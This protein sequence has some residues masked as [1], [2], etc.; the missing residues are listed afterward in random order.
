MSSPM[1]LLKPVRLTR[2]DLKL[3][4]WSAYELTSECV[5][6][7]DIREEQFE[8]FESAGVRENVADDARFLEFFFVK[9]G[10]PKRS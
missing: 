2:E 9:I 4:E 5:V 7:H 3:F 6:F 8:L 1:T 10:N